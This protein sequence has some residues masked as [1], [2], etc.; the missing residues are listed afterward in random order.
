MSTAEVL[1]PEPGVALERQTGRRR[2][3]ARPFAAGELVE[4]MHAYQQ[5]CNQLLTDG[6]YQEFSQRERVGDRWQTVKK[7][8]K[9][10]SAWRKLALAFDLDVELLEVVVDRDQDGKPVRARATARAVTP[11]GRRQ[12]GDGYCSIDESRFQHDD[13]VKQ[14][15]R[16]ERAENDLPATAST[17]AKNRAISDLLGTG[18]VSAEEMTGGGPDEP[19]GVAVRAGV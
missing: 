5:L 4:N 13:P 18:E 1:D 14:L 19:L 17:R 11:S 16:R 9:K 8:F 12:D 15:Q 2:E 7:R 10:K 6:D 3:I